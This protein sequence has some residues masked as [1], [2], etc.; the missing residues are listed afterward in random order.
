[1]AWCGVVWCVV[2]LSMG[3]LAIQGSFSKVTDRHLPHM[4]VLWHGVARCGV[5]WLSIGVLAS[6]GSFSEA[7]T[8][9]HPPHSPTN[10]QTHD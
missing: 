6:Q 2:W 5:V 3:V 8:I 1:M 7:T 9:H 4:C 10:T